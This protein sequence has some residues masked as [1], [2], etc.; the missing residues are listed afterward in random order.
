MTRSGIPARGGRPQTADERGLEPTW[1]DFV[2]GQTVRL[3]GE[4]GPRYTVLGFR[5]GDL[6]ELYPT[7]NNAHGGQRTVKAGRLRKVRG[8]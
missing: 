6:A 2:E 7:G 4:V 8:G 1:G 5:P 3:Q